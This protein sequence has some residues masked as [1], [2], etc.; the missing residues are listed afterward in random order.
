MWDEQEIKLWLKASVV[1]RYMNRFSEALAWHRVM[2]KVS[3]QTLREPRQARCR[4]GAR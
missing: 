4:R 1:D 3:A 2:E